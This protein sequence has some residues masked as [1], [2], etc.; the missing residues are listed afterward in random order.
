[1]LDVESTKYHSC[2]TLGYHTHHLH[3]T[4]LHLVQPLYLVLFILLFLS[5][6][7][8]HT[9]THA[10]TLVQEVQQWG[11]DTCSVQI[12]KHTQYFKPSLRAFRAWLDWHTDWIKTVEKRNCDIK[13]NTKHP[14]RPFRLYLQCYYHTDAF[15][16]I[17]SSTMSIHLWIFT[18]C[19]LLGCYHW[20]Q[21]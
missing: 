8:T 6:S 11:E 3:S 21:Q 20:S 2:C 5:P 15:E 18:C 13:V 9:H 10:V 12:N 7:G 14:L 1:M 17:S 16:A 19:M 4:S